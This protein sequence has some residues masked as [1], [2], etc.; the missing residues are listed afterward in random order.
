MYRSPSKILQLKTSVAWNNQPLRHGMQRVL[1]EC[2][3]IF[4]LLTLQIIYQGQA[5]YDTKFENSL[6]L[7]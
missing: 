7:A 3:T 5:E 2:N 4:E 6:Q 1:F